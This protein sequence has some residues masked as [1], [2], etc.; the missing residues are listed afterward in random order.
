[1][2]GL[3]TV[4]S[5]VAPKEN[6]GVGAEGTKQLDLIKSE[7]EETGLAGFFA[8][9][10]RA[11]KSVLTPNGLPPLP[12]GLSL[13]TKTGEKKYAMDGEQSYEGQ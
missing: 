5:K 7:G 2:V 12:S 13:T 11:V 4:G 8:K 3:L 6:L 10:K 9:D 1:M